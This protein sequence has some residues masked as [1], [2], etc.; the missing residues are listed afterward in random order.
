MCKAYVSELMKTRCSIVATAALV[1]CSPSDADFARACKAV[2]H[3]EI[4]DT[5][6]WK[7]YL[8]EWEALPRPSGDEKVPEILTF[9][10]NFV[11]EGKRFESVRR[12]AENKF[13]KDEWQ[14]RERKT[15]KVIAI[16]RTLEWLDPHFG[17]SYSKN[18]IFEYPQ[19][20]L[21]FNRAGR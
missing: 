14:I 11:A 19:H 20:Y 3:I 21:P 9:T 12:L 15:G 17:Y 18:C 4:I 13:T 16:A 6:N 1:G 2:A 8:A 7:N 5:S 10:D